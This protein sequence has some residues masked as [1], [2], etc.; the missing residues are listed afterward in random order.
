M[1]KFIGVLL[2]VVVVGGFVWM[3]K[4]Q[5]VGK[6]E[7]G[8]SI[9][10]TSR[11]VYD[12]TAEIEKIS[13]QI[14]KEYPKRPEEVV[15]IHNKLMEICYRYPMDEKDVEKYVKIIRQ[16]YTNKFNELNAEEAQ[17]AALNKERQT[18]S[19]EKMELVISEITGVYVAQNEKGEEISAEVN[20]MYATNLGGLSRTYLLTD[21]NGVWKINGWE[22]NQIEE[23]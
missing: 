22:D 1:R 4:E 11:K 2:M 14:E 12:A 9:L 20:V 23:Q 13:K 15:E 10:K 7:N 3:T 17:I 6:D 19:S 5:M 8:K 21:E 16:L 18:M